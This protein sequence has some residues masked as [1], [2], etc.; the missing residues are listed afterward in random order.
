MAEA[1]VLDLVFGTLRLVLWLGL[2]FVL[3]S[4]VVGVAAGVFQTGT[5]I[6]DP[7]IATVPR[8]VVVGFAVLLLGPWVLRSLVAVTV[9]LFGDFG[10]ILGGAG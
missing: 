6:Q 9:A 10:A 2:P 4:L 1:S 7:S 8:L 3:L 5:S